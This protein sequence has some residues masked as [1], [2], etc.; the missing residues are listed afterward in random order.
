MVSDVVASGGMWKV[1]MR[2]VTNGSIEVPA[3][4]AGASSV[5]NPV[6]NH[7]VADRMELF[8]KHTSLWCDLFVGGRLRRCN[9]TS[10]IV[11][12][13]LK[14]NSRDGKCGRFVGRCM[15]TLGCP[16]LVSALV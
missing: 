8:F 13:V 15:L 10:E 3:R 1:V 4:A 12:N 16:R 9:S 14:N 7:K 5:P 11:N 6:C 2:G